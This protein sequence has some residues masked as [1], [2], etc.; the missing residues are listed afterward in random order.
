MTCVTAPNKSL[1]RAVNHKVHGRGR[2][3][4][5]SWRTPRAPRGGPKQPPPAK[6]TKLCNKNRACFK[7]TYKI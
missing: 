4:S 3:V 5:A 6:K 2:E 1:Q 7:K